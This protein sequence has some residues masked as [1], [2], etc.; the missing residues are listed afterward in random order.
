MSTS[1]SEPEQ[2]SSFIKSFEPFDRDYDAVDLREL[3]DRSS[4]EL[5]DF[6]E[7]QRPL[8]SLRQVVYDLADRL[9]R[10]EVKEQE[11]SHFSSVSRQALEEIGVRVHA[12]DLKA[13]ALSE[14]GHRHLTSGDIVIHE[15][16]EDIR[17][18][19]EHV[20]AGASDSVTRM[21]VDAVLGS[22]GEII[23]QR[24]NHRQELDV[25]TNLCSSWAVQP[26]CVEHPTTKQQLWLHGEVDYAMFRYNT[27]DELVQNCLTKPTP[28]VLADL[29]EGI[30]EEGKL[31]GPLVSLR[32][33]AEFAREPGPVDINTD[34]TVTECICQMLK[35]METTAGKS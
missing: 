25:Y 28:R 22:L 6:K 26:V 24:S 33:K 27:E 4:V 8:E 10:G 15:L 11:S 23:R 29:K 21:F 32:A 17:F 9:E 19:S 1:S 30:F 18:M 3:V 35:L 34:H 20:E 12:V 7:L 5:Q 13:G 16:A 31:L 2:R 14:L